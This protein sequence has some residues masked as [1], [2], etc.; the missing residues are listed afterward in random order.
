MIVALTR[1]N[2]KRV[3]KFCVSRI[4]TLTEF[5]KHLWNNNIRIS[6]HRIKEIRYA[7]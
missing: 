1:Q 5:V 2:Q 4:H 3:C 6:V 7:T